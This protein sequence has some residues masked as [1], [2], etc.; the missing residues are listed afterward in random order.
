AEAAR[1]GAVTGISALLSAD[2]AA[3]DEYVDQALAVTT[4]P[5]HDRL[6]AARGE[7]RGAIAELGAVST[8]HVISAGILALPER[9]TR[10]DGADGSVPVLVVAQASAPELVGGVA[11]TD[12]VA[13]RVTMLQSGDRWLIFSTERVS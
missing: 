1:D 12:R 10:V 11:G 6:S 8:G 7:L 2:P 4:G 5:Q 13:L 3:P 9:G